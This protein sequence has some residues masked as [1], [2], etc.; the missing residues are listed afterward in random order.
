MAKSSNTGHEAVQRSWILN[1]ASHFPYCLSSLLNGLFCIYDAQWLRCR[2]NR[3]PRN[4]RFVASCDII[5]PHKKLNS[6]L[7]NTDFLMKYIVIGEISDMV[8]N[9]LGHSTQRFVGLG[10]AGTGK[11][12]LLHH[13]THNSCSSSGFLFLRQ[14]LKM[15]YSQRSFATYDRC[16]ILE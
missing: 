1:C 5:N 6:N 9:S 8:I 14:Y 10:E 2:R 11:S 3:A 15:S 4:I 12:C 7:W 16:W 13:F